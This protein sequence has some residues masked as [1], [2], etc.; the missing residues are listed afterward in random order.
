[1]HARGACKCMLDRRGGRGGL[2]DVAVR[3]RER[4]R[5]RTRA[6]TRARARGADGPEDYSF[7]PTV[8]RND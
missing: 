3:G 7:V 4:T 1:M 5:G 8:S 6:R 2:S